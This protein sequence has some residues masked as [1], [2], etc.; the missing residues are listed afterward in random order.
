MITSEETPVVEDIRSRKQGNTQAQG[1]SNTCQTNV[2]RETERNRLS[3]KQSTNDKG[4]GIATH[5]EMWRERKGRTPNGRRKQSTTDQG[6]DAETHVEMWRERQ[7]RTLDGGR[8]EG[9]REAEQHVR[10]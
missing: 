3:K 2:Q 8:Q 10:M 6:N 1:E 4:N 7:G 5:V 9:T